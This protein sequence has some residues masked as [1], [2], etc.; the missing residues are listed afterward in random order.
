MSTAIRVTCEVC[1]EKADIQKNVH[2]DATGK[3]VEWPKAAVR[4]DGLY[5][6]LSCPECGDREQRMAQQADAD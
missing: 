1:G 6:A 5:F 2:V 3:R 4:P